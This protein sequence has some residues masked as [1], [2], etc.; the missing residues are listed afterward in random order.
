VRAE[1]DAGESD[2]AAGGTANLD[3]P[4]YI[5]FAILHI[6]YTEARLDGSS[7][8][9]CPS[10]L[11]SEGPGARVGRVGVP[12][13]EVR[14]LRLWEDLPGRGVDGGGDRLRSRFGLPR[15]FIWGIPLAILSFRDS[16]SQIFLGPQEQSSWGSE[17]ARRG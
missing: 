15:L 11:E 7:D 5:P 6:E 1:A 2:L 16:Q 14:A 13:R 17:I 4:Q 3:A 12:V 9:G 10:P 8:H